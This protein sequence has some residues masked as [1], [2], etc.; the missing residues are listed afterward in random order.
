MDGSTAGPSGIQMAFATFKKDVV[1]SKDE[2]EKLGQKWQGLLKTD[3]INVS[4]Y[5]ISESELLLTEQEGKIF[6]VKEFIL[7]Q[8]EVEKFRWK[9]TDFT[10]LPKAAS[11]PKKRTPTKPAGKPGKPGAKPTKRT[12]PRAPTKTPVVEEIDLDEKKPEL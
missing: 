3:G 10:P 4:I 6:A 1:A 9:D 5:P 7:S 12:I 2:A 11:T 8:P